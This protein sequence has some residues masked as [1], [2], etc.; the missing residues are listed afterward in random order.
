MG[1][2]DIGYFQPMR[3]HPFGGTTARRTSSPWR[4][5]SRFTPPPFLASTGAKART[6]RSIPLPF[7]PG[8]RTRIPRERYQRSEKA[9][10][11]A[12]AEMYVRGV[13]TCK[14]K[15]ITPL[16]MFFEIEPALTDT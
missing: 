10:V 14:V 9:L 7:R 12:L 1:A 5:C 11:S 6:M 15:A 3:F 16:K 4:A 13:S 8:E 2:D